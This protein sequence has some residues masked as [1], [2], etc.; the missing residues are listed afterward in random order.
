LMRPGTICQ[1]ARIMTVCKYFSLSAF[2]GVGAAKWG[3]GRG[4]VHRLQT[5]LLSIFYLDLP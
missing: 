2:C 3:K 1:N 5:G 4:E